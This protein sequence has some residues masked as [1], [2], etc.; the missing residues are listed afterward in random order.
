MI[1]GDV[2]PLM[3]DLDEETCGAP[4]TVLPTPRSQVY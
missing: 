1:H 2:H 4:E 3:G